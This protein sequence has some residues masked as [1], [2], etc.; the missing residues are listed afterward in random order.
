MLR[1][2]RATFCQHEAQC[3]RA[4]RFFSGTP[5][6]LVSTR[7]DSVRL[8]WALCSVVALGV[9]SVVDFNMHIPGNA[10]VFAFIFGT[11]ASPGF[12]KKADW[13]QKFRH[14]FD[15]WL[16]GLGVW[17]AITAVQRFPPN[18]R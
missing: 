12:E 7:S 11:L 13:Q 17:L 4:F 3:L 1:A 9:H 6:A 18:M 5:F 10:L 15:S 8:M 14:G 16:P 2:N